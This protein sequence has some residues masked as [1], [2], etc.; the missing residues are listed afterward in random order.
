[1]NKFSDRFVTVFFQSGGV[2]REKVKILNEAITAAKIGAVYTQF[3]KDGVTKAFL[4]A[5]N[6]KEF[7]RAEKFIVD[8][9]D[10]YPRG[11]FEWESNAVE[12]VIERY[13]N[14]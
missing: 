6:D 1:M 13:K 7:K 8:I 12:N 4:D 9:N 11:Q 5:T 3:R 10:C 14:G 2:I